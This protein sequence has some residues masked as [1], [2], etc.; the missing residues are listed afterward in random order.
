MLSDRLAFNLDLPTLRDY[1]YESEKCEV[2]TQRAKQELSCSL[3]KTRFH[4]VM[5][6]DRYK[7]T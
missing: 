1:Q 3:Y 6:S 4:A 5:Q 2:R 7:N